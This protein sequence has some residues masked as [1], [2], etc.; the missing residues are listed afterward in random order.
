MSDEGDRC[1]S[2]A[3]ESSKGKVHWYPQLMSVS[4]IEAIKV[5]HLDPGRHEVIDKVPLSAVIGK[6]LRS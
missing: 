5:H 2:Q 1:Y 6:S 4:Y 3:A